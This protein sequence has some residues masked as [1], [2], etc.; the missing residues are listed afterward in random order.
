MSGHQG[1]RFQRVPSESMTSSSDASVRRD[2]DRGPPETPPTSPPTPGRLLPRLTRMFTLSSNQ[3]ALGGQEPRSIGLKS[4]GLNIKQIAL[5]ADYKHFV[6]WTVDKLGLFDDAS[7]REP[8]V[9]PNPVENPVQM[10]ASPSYCAIVKRGQ[11]S[12]EVWLHWCCP[13]DLL[14]SALTSR[15]YS[16]IR[17][18]VLNNLTFIQLRGRCAA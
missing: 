13:R 7:E 3:A 2:P 10:V 15:L 17:T 16:S 18:N 4:L 9:V 14:T 1:H 12:D 8:V 11:N 6:F 5:S